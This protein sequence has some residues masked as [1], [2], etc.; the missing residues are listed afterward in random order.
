M[1]IIMHVFFLLSQ[2]VRIV[3]GDSTGAIGMVVPI[4][5][6]VLISTHGARDYFATNQ[7]GRQPMYQPPGHPHQP[8]G[9]FHQPP[10]GMYPPPGHQY[11]PPG[12]APPPRG[13]MYQPP[14]YR[15]PSGRMPRPLLVARILLFVMAAVQIFAV[16]ALGLEN[17]LDGQLTLFLIG[18]LLY[19]GAPGVLALVCGLYLPRGRRVF[20]WFLIVVQVW[21]IVDFLRYVNPFVPIFFPIAVLVCVLWPS[22][23]KYLLHR[24][25]YP[26]VAA[27]PRRGLA[28]PS[29]TLRPRRAV[30]TRSR[31]TDG[32]GRARLPC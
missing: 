14:H 12:S 30:S 3:A 32:T 15:T 23:R 4:V 31:P 27:H 1:I 7:A 28:H 11:P 5:G 6:L 13:G 16:T 22:A 8:P 18:G 2:L 24:E 21:F 25:H 29:V 17:H 19:L 26:W 10:G 20:F 9:N